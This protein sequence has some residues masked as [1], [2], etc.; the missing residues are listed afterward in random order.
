MREALARLQKALEINPDLPEG[1]FN[2][3][4][5]LV[6]TGKAQEAESALAQALIV[7]PYDAAAYAI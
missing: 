6:Q 5:L 1:Y 2:L 4:N 3:A 7:D